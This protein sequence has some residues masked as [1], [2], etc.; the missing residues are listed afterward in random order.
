MEYWRAKQA[1][2]DVGSGFRWGDGDLSYGVQVDGN[3]F[4][5]DGTGDEGSLLACSRGAPTST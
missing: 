2:G 1:P 5:Q 4:I 3:V